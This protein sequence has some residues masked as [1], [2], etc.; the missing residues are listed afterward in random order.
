MYYYCRGMTALGDD[1]VAPAG[2][3]GRFYKGG[4]PTSTYHILSIL[5]IRCSSVV[6]VVMSGWIFGNMP[7][8]IYPKTARRRKVPPTQQPS[9]SP[10]G[11]RSQ[12]RRATIF[13]S[14]PTGDSK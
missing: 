14:C 11:R 10:N 1:E 2:S 5:I 8:I 13:Q 7:V 9:R 6:V 3:T 4:Q 12:T